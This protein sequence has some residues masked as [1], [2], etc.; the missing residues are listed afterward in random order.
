LG[1][2]TTAT[3]RLH[4][5]LTRTRTVNYVEEELAAL[6][7]VAKLHRRQQ[8]YDIVCELL[9]QVWPPA[10]CGPYALIHADARS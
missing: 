4:H 6:T 1:D 9:D 5:A 8:H 2:L 3:E 10:G 7:A